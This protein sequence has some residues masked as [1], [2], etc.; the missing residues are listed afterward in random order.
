LGASPGEM[1]VFRLIIRTSTG[2][3]KRDQ[4]RVLARA[5]ALEEPKA[6]L[7]DRGLELS[8]EADSRDIAKERVEAAVHGIRSHTGVY[9]AGE[10]RL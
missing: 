10:V 1:S 4:V 8:V 6:E 5:A 2:W 9:L 3:S 7:T